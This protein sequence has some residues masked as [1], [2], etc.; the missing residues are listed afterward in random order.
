MPLMQIVSCPRIME[1]IHK[2]IHS[3]FDFMASTKPAPTRT[4]PQ[5]FSEGVSAELHFKLDLL[6]V[7]SSFEVA[8]VV[9]SS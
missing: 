8:E 9:Q 2:F 6:V 4:L 1:R 5:A 3:L 7:T